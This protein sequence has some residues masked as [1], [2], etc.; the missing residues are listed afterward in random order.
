MTTTTTHI[1]LSF[2]LASALLCDGRAQPQ[3]STR[4]AHEPVARFEFNGSLDNAAAP[5]VTGSTDGTAA[6]VR[7]LEGRALSLGAGDSATSLTIEGADLPFDPGNDF[8]VQCWIR[9]TAESGSRMV[10]LSQKD[11][12]EGS[13]ASQKV[14]SWVFYMSGGTWAWNMGSGKRRIT[15][16]RDNG[17]HMPLNDGRWHQLTMTYDSDLAQ[18]WLYYDGVNR[19]IYN[20]RDSTGFDFTSAQPLT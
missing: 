12:G 4:R 9:T 17:E 6:F 11:Y 7:G 14:P 1:I 10:L 5:S 8:S 19:A 16:E 2:S 3:A 13:L 18:V 15:Y 20:V